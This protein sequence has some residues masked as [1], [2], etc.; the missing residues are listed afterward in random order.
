MSVPAERWAEIAASF[1]EL[2]E[3]APAQRAARLAQIAREDPALAREVEA[4][5][6]ADEADH[7]L[8]EGG[9]MQAMPAFA[10]LAGGDASVG[11]VAGPYRLLRRL[12]EGG[13][14]VVWLAE[15]IDGAYEQHV[16]VKLLRPGMDSHAIVRRFLQERRIL[17]RLSHPHVVRL[18]DGGMS[19]SRRPYYVMEYVDGTTITQYAAQRQADVRTRVAL[20]AVAAD[21]VAYA[22]ANLIVH[23]DLKPSNVLVDRDGQP[24]VLD[25]GIAKLIEEGGE[26]TLTGTAWRVLSPAYAAP[27]QILGEPV[28]TATDV[29]ALGLVLCELLVGELPQRRRAAQLAE[30]ATKEITLRASTIASGLPPDRVAGLYGAALD[31]RSLVRSVSGDLDLI[32]ATAL[33]REPARRYATA[34]AFAAD[35]RRW[36]DGR[37]IEARADSAAYRLGKFVRR[38]RAG[39]AASALVACALLGGFGVALWQAGVA[40]QQAQRADAERVLAQRQL[41]RTERVK[42]FIL[43]LFREQDPISRAKAR[44]RSATDLVREGV[45]QTDATLASDPDL[46]AELLRDLGEIQIGLDDRENA[47]Q[48]LERAWNLQRRASG[49]DSVAAA[50]ALA[51]YADAVS[52]GGDMQAAEPMFRDALARLRAAGEGQ[53]PSILPA[54]SKLALIELVKANH[55]EA[56]RLARHALEVAR[57]AWGGDSVRLV[58]HLLTLGKVQQEIPRYEDALR[59]YREALRITVGA[60]GEEHVRTAMLHA[61]IADVLRV[62]D[63]EDEALAEYAA[64]LRVVRAQLP[65]GH[66]TLASMLTRV[67]DL[68]RRRGDLDAA[69]KAIDEAIAILAAGQASGPY[70]QALQFQADLLLARGRADAAVQ[71]YA[72]AVA[73]FRAATGESA[74]VATSTLKR[75][76][77]LVRAGRLAEAEAACLEAQGVLARL[78]QDE[79]LGGY[80]AS[81]LGELRHAQARYAEAAAQRRIVLALTSKIYAAGHPEIAVARIALADSLVAMR[82]AAQRAEAATLLEDARAVLERPDAAGDAAPLGE[83]YLA[84]AALRLDEGDVAAARADV[85]KAMPRLAKKPQPE[86]TL[87]RARELARRLGVRPA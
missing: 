11:A 22:H 62:L 23:R 43:A 20:L 10:E 65:A 54:E 5:L 49:A 50:K 21:A 47:A 51:S 35:L 81:V 44:A 41:A 31:R 33:Q 24:R 55:A 6:A 14:G 53:T 25:F 57:A 39:V 42:D 46:Q 8:L 61:S 83:L 64:A 59:T 63:R 74:Y 19:A 68:Q 30:D 66:A 12:G 37:P 56:E 16:A 4:L 48:T 36:L 15:R 52:A 73:T 45:V 28:G 34:A 76:G 38:H 9:A 72:Q 3:L 26:Q 58:P 27:E 85:G 1:D 18:L 87:R 77:A 84:R 60:S 75:A 71:R 29:Y 69:E 78:P 40:R 82:D 79:Y 2:V 86:N 80:A 7:A 13:M 67:A 32:I 70:A 17:A